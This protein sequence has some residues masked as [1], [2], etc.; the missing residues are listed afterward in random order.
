MDTM[1]EKT[2]NQSKQ[3]LLMSILFAV[4]QTG[5]V[6]TSTINYGLDLEWTIRS[7]IMM[8]LCFLLYSSY[9]SHTKNVMK[10]LLGATLML[11]L[12]FALGHV[13]YYYTYLNEFLDCFENPTIFLVFFGSCILKLIAVVVMNVMHYRINST[14]ES[15]PKEVKFN[16]TVFMIYVLLLATEIVACIGMASLFTEMI[17][18]TLGVF[19]D[20]FMVAIIILIEKNMDEFKIERE[21]KLKN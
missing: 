15:R 2:G 10:P 12:V 13:C 16:Y 4:F 14:H 3:L 11:L 9:K 6:I 8:V 20:A 21:K 7:I 18:D 17:S 5:S 1:K 19:A